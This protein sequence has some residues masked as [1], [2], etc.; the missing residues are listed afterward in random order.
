M[1]YTR[2]T[3][4]LYL[5]TCE[6]CQCHGHADECHPETGECQVSPAL[7]WGQRGGH[8][9]DPLAVPASPSPPNTRAAGTTRRAR[10]VTSA[11]LATTA[12]PPVAPRE[13]A[14]PAPATGPT[15]TPSRCPPPPPHAPRG[16]QLGLTHRPAL[17]SPIQELL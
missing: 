11:S 6:R 17:P 7:A 8:G 15:L 16:H 12:M 1:G 5:G 10:S 13:T 9:G 2:S 14:G 4:G 3:S